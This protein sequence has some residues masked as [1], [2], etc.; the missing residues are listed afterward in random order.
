ML[1]SC[2]CRNIIIP[3]HIRFIKTILKFTCVFEFCQFENIFE[4]CQFCPQS[5]YYVYCNKNCES[6]VKIFKNVNKN[7]QLYHWIAC[8]DVYGE[9][10]KLSLN[11]SITFNQER[12]NHY[13]HFTIVDIAKLLWTLAPSPSIADPRFLNFII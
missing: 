5:R 8:F 1:P 6:W 13:D 4:R 11:Q 7:I 3:L 12:N 2:D 9:T 10:W